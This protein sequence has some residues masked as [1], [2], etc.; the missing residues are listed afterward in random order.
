MKTELS[1]STWAYTTKQCFGHGTTNSAFR[2]F[3][4]YLI[5]IRSY[6]L[7]KNFQIKTRKIFANNLVTFQILTNLLL[8]V[9]Y[10]SWYFKYIIKF[11]VSDLDPDPDKGFVSLRNRVPQH[12]YVYPAA[13]TPATLLLAKKKGGLRSILILLLDLVES[14]WW[15]P[16]SSAV[17]A[18]SF[19]R[20]FSASGTRQEQEGIRLASLT[21]VLAQIPSVGRCSAEARSVEAMV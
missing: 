18:P 20:V 11:L 8:S 10:F 9:E 17:L 21:T 14:F 13:R 12:C 16:P 1:P 6:L 4:P 19:S 2:L 15:T 5:R 3:R 7:E